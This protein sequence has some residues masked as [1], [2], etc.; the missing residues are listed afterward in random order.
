MHKLNVGKNIYG[1]LALFSIV[2]VISGLVVV[3]AVRS[4]NTPTPIEFKAVSF[5]VLKAHGTILSAPDN[6]STVTTNST[7]LAQNT[8]ASTTPTVQEAQDIAQTAASRAFDGATVRESFFAHCVS[9]NID[10]DCWAV[11]LDPTT[12]AA[13]LPGPPTNSLSSATR[14]SLSY[15]IVLIDPGSGDVLTALWGGP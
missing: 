2:V 6:P 1:L 11:S 4:E 12:F 10:Q 5:D 13:K 14:S 7:G 3:S 8:S 9:L 15:L